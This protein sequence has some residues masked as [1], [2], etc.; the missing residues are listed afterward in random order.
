[1]VRSTKPYSPRLRLGSFV[2]GSRRVVSD[3]CSAPRRG[4]PPPR[5]ILLFQGARNIGNDG[6]GAALQNHRNNGN[7]KTSITAATTTSAK[8]NTA[9]QRPSV[10][11][12]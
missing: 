11:M 2:A 5:S 1:M 6:L 8:P 4:H 7:T 10:S 12:W 9:S 3:K